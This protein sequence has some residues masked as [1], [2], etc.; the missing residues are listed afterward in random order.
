MTQ[1]VAATE[2]L[3]ELSHHMSG[4]AQAQIDEMGKIHKMEVDSI[5]TQMAHDKQQAAAQIAELTRLVDEYGQI[6]LQ[7]IPKVHNHHHLRN[8]PAPPPPLTGKASNHE[9]ELAP[10]PPPVRPAT[11]LHKGTLIYDKIQKLELAANVDLDGDGDI[12]PDVSVSPTSP[13]PLMSPQDS[14]FNKS[15][16][17]R[18]GHDEVETR[19]KC[20]VGML[21]EENNDGYVHVLQIN[22]GNNSLQPSTG[23]SRY[24]L[25]D[26]ELLLTYTPFSLT[27]IHTCVF[28]R[29][30]GV[31]LPPNWHW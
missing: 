16:S 24:Y 31:G 19:R 6:S 8:A 3:E 4:D 22:H 27:H 25:R 30:C 11:G 20:G 26:S 21:V 14:F 18:S 5:A 17:Q 7:Q 2:A 12:A 9:D 10:P 15:L 13:P 29:W 1:L 23:G 28:P